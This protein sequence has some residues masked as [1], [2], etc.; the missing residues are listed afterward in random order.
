[1]KER[2]VVDTNV[3]I[4]A[5]SAVDADS[6]VAD[7]ATPQDPALRMKVWQWL[8]EFQQAVSHLVLDGQGKIEAEYNHNIKMNTAM[9]IPPIKSITELY[10]RWPGVT[11]WIGVTRPIYVKI[12]NLPAR[13][14]QNFVLET[15]SGQVENFR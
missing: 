7:D 15:P 10:D 12:F 5:S 8:D 2:Y 6:P 9:S 1:M 4:A 3:L 14:F 13:G 11:P